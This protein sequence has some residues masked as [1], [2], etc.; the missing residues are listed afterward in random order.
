MPLTETMRQIMAAIF[1]LRPGT[2]MPLRGFSADD[3]AVTAANEA[4][5]FRPE[6]FSLEK[7][8]WTAADTD[9]AAQPAI[10]AMGLG[11]RW[12]AR[13]GRT[14]TVL[15]PTSGVMVCDPVTHDNQVVEQRLTMY[16]SDDDFARL[17]ARPTPDG[18]KF[19]VENARLVYV[20]DQSLATRFAEAVHDHHG[21]RRLEPVLAR[22]I[23]G[24]RG[25]ARIDASVPA[26]QNTAGQLDSWLAG[27]EAVLWR[28]AA[29][30]GQDGTTVGELTAGEMV[31]LYAEVMGQASDAAEPSW[32]RINAGFV[33]DRLR[34]PGD[35]LQA[36]Y[37]LLTDDYRE[38]GVASGGKAASRAELCAVRRGSLRSVVLQP[39]GVVPAALFSFA[40][41]DPV[42]VFGAALNT[43]ADQPMGLRTSLPT[44]PR[45]TLQQLW[46][47][48][49]IQHERLITGPTAVEEFP[50]TDY[51]DQV[52]I[53]QGQTPLRPRAFYDD[54]VNEVTYGAM[55]WSTGAVAGSGVE[56]TL[57]PHGDIAARPFHPR[58]T[59]K[60]TLQL[61][62]L[63]P[64]RFLIRLGTD[65]DT[66]HEFSLTQDERDCIRQEHVFHM[67]FV[68]PYFQTYRW[69]WNVQERAARV[70]PTR[71]PTHLHEV[72]Y[73]QDDP[74]RRPVRPAIGLDGRIRV[75]RRTDLRPL[76][77]EEPRDTAYHY[78]LLASSS[79]AL[80]E[81][82]RAAAAVYAGDVM[83]LLQAIADNL[84]PPPVTLPAYA[85]QVV[86]RIATLQASPPLQI[87]GTAGFLQLQLGRQDPINRFA[88]LDAAGQFVL[89]PYRLQISSGWRPP[90]HNESVSL[91][92]ISNHQLGEAM[93][94]QPVGAGPSN[95]NPLGL[96]CLHLA[97]QDFQRADQLRECL[98]EQQT[99]EY[100]IGHIDG[101]K[102][103]RTIIENVLPDGS[104]EYVLRAAGIADEPFTNVA[105]FDGE[106]LTDQTRFDLNLARS[107]RE[108]LNRANNSTVPW[109]GP[110]YLDMY[111]FGLCVASHV[112]HTW[113]I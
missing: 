14:V 22:G 77:P 101:A 31:V 43:P 36:E 56:R 68:E 106:Q 15:A 97:A 57:I 2:R 72:E 66:A 29:G 82:A 112:H 111:I 90:E 89:R 67:Y 27:E 110:T 28:F 49:G 61:R 58:W 32:Y 113:V 102:R 105:S 48:H 59:P 65:V 73:E 45:A 7:L 19:A 6:T 42:H 24:R 96:L 23:D 46:Q 74:N 99:Q 40:T 12:T 34:A 54:M 5:R 71:D 17:R 75:P 69:R 9:A 39:F 4:R 60:R 85:T 100:I 38:R 11:L 20:M 103:D 64:L 81:R 52:T 88:R 18:E 1:G 26:E 83:R 86:T 95:R 94:V 79:D 108:E 16:L 37:D 10:D 87:S 25:L 41:C 21:S 84:P 3:P 91:T 35:G 92:P 55:G 70:F 107:Y 63:F 53:T 47:T 13:P 30:V 80:L 104:R 78:T 51:P 98:L 76:L 62:R 109:P 44:I 33:L 93:D 50:A 8:H